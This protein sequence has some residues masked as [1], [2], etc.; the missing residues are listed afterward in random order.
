M[1][2]TNDDTVGRRNT[3]ASTHFLATFGCSQGEKLF[4]GTY[5]CIGLFDSIFVAPSFNSIGELLR[6]NCIQPFHLGRN[7]VGYM[8]GNLIS[9][10]ISDDIPPQMKMLN[11][12]ISILMHFCS[13]PGRVAQSVTCLAT[14][15][16][17]TADPG[18][19]S[20]IPA[21]SHTLT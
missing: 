15:V 16:S 4:K 6:D 7:I 10:C 18:V 13:L 1:V 14:N 8:V 3:S 17:L 2:S 5:T 11:R 20:S 12:V 21:R 19:V 9:E